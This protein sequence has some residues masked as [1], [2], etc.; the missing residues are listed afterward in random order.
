MSKDIANWIR[1]CQ[2][3]LCYNTE[4]ES[5]H[6]AKS[7]VAAALWDH[8]EIDLIGPLPES[9]QRHNYILIVIDVCSN[10]T[11]VCAL[12]NKEMESVAQAM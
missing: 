12:L 10:Y 1:R 4:K 5:Y 2:A 11:I 3:C 8:I 6:P 7:V 9:E